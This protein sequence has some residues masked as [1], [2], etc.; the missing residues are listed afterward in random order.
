MPFLRG[1]IY[2]A[3]Q[4]LPGTEAFLVVTNDRWN[5]TMSQIGVLPVR[6]IVP[7]HDAP[8]SAPLPDG[9]Q[10]LASRLVAPDVSSGAS[11]LLGVARGAVT[12]DVLAAVEDRLVLFLQ[13]DRLVAPAPRIPRPVGDATRY[14]IWG[15]IYLAGPPVDGERKRRIVVSPNAWNAVSGLATL[16]R[17][18]T[19]F[20]YDDVAFPQIQGGA[21][22]ACCG[23]ATT[24]VHGQIR[25]SERERPEPRAATMAE[26]TRLAKGL[27]ATHELDRAIARLVPEAFGVK[28]TI[29]WSDKPNL[30][31]DAVKDE[32]TTG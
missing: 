13:L 28:P 9:S 17:T 14:P 25:L 1:V 32:E 19:A 12:D 30:I 26:M 15:D 8:Y 29:I 22:R 21:A 4:Q 20:K 31:D 2:A 3:A 16:V 24:M 7:E 23:D 11:P 27:I 18:T 10:I 6:R 5:Q